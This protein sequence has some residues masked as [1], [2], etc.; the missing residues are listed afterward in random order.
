MV[1]Q[2]LATGLKYLQQAASQHNTL[3]LNAL[4]EAMEQGVGVTPDLDQAMD[5]YRQ[6]AAQV[7]AD[8]YGHLGRLY[9]KGIGVERDIATAREWLEKASLLG[10]QPSSELLKHINAYLHVG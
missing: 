3:A 6:A 2:D 9:T 10:H 8:A 4:G 7:N 5:Y 1:E